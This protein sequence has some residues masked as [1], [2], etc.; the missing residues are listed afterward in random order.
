MKK[1]IRTADKNKGVRGYAKQ[2]NGPWKEVIIS[3]YQ[4]IQKVIGGYFQIVPIAEKFTL[5]CDDEGKLKELEPN[6]IW[7]DTDRTM[8]DILVGPILLL[9]PVDREGNDTNATPEMLDLL[10]R[11]CSE[12]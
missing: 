7:M 2:P 3:D 10:K 8:I 5:Y 4:D 9:G 1:R 6:L 12:V 11:H